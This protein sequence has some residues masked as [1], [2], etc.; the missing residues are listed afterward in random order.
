MPKFILKF[1]DLNADELLA[2]L[3]Y[4]FTANDLDAVLNHLVSFLQGS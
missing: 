1:I 3:T 4:E 2:N